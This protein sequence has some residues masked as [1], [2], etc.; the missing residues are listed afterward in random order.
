MIGYV[1]LL[2]RPAILEGA[3]LALMHLSQIIDGRPT[4]DQHP[5]SLAGM[6]GLLRQTQI[7]FYPK[8]KYR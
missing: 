5:H 6:P 2:V 4:V 7:Q 8:A 3:I 1:L